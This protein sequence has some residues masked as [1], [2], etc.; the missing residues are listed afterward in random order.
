MDGGL[1]F[2]S[3]NVI[4]DP[5]DAKLNYDAAGLIP[6]VVQDVSTG[7]V[8]MLAYMNEKSLKKT[9]ETGR[10]WFYSRSRS[11]LWNKGETSGN[12]Q[13]VRSIYIDCD[14]DTLLVRVAQTGV[15]CHLGTKTCFSRLMARNASRAESPL[16]EFPFVLED[17]IR[18]RRKKGK[19]ES[20]VASL[21]DKGL[22]SILKK[23]GEEGAEV[24]IAAKNEHKEELVHEAADLIFH[25]LLVLQAKGVSYSE[26]LLELMER[27]QKKEAGE[28]G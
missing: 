11:A 16:A 1:T 4:T 19:A 7:E 26:V 23:I 28:E 10:T 12:I 8:L 15:A 24:V 25:L 5:H 2:V 18:Q 13:E 27:H 3:L 22:D 21:F 17:I 20:Y 14:A 9:L 6:A